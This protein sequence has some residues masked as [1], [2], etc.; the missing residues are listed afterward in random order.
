MKDRL[1]RKKYMGV[2][3]CGLPAPHVEAE[4]A[5]AGLACAL[6]VCSENALWALLATE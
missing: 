2:C 6:S 3:L 4:N 1:L 5:P